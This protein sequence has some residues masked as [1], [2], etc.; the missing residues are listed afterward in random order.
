VLWEYSDLSRGS[1]VIP[2][3]AVRIRLRSC[4]NVTWNTYTV[5][6][7]GRMVND[8]MI[9]IVMQQLQ[10]LTVFISARA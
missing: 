9:E 6:S 10:P 1:N 3:Y 5:H 8:I 4:I 7:P 2:L